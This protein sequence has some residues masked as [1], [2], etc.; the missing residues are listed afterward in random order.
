M[1]WH[2]WWG[3]LGFLGV[4]R[5]QEWSSTILCRELTVSA[6]QVHLP[7]VRLHTLPLRLH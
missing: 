7:H 3:R 5:C 2:T 1:S 4:R 6:L